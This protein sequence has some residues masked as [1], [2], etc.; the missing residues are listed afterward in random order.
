[1]NARLFLV[2]LYTLLL[3]NTAPANGVAIAD[4]GNLECLH[5]EA[6]RVNALVENQVSQVVARQEFRNLGETPRIVKYGFPL[7][8]DASATRL[9]WRQDGVW[10]EAGIA[11]AP[12]DTTLPGG[13]T[14]HPSLRQHLGNTPLYYDLEEAV[15]PDSQLV[16]ELSYVQLL[17]YDFGRVGFDFPADY[18]LIQ[19]AP[20]DRQEFAFTLESE[21]TILDLDHTGIPVDSLVAGTHFAYLFHDEIEEPADH[22]FHLSYELDPEELGLFGF[23]TLLPDSLLPDAGGNGYFAFV[24]EPDPSQ[25][26]DVIQKVFTLVIDRSGSMSGQ[27]IV[28]ARGAASTIVDNLNPADR[29]NLVSFSSSVHSFRPGHVEATAANRQAAHE[30]IESLYASGSTNVAG[31]FQEAIPQFGAADGTTAN[32]LVFFTDG[33]ANV[34]ES[35]TDGILELVEELDQQNEAQ[36]LIFT[37]GIGAHVNEQLLVRLASE[38]DG[39]CEFLGNDELEERITSFFLRINNPVL[40]DTQINF[41]TEGVSEVYPD[42]LPN[43]YLGS[44]M[45]VSGRYSQ[46]EPLQI[47]LHGTA[48]GQPVSYEY[49]LPVAD[50]LDPERHFLPKIWAKQKIEHLAVAY[51]SLDPESQEADELMEQI[52][53]LSQ[54][55]GVLSPFTSFSGETDIED[56]G[57]TEGEILPV[58]FELPG[59]LP[60]PFN[61]S[62]RIRFRTGVAL[63]RLVEV[64]IYNTLG[65]LVRVLHM[66][67]GGA[68]L[69]EVR[70]DG[71]TEAGRPAA[72]GSY[73][74]VV[75]FGRGLLAD[76]MTLI[77]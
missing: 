8:E 16:V 31:A 56:E 64:R 11:A 37:F 74:Y 61:G 71:L 47:V 54:G 1:M 50:A 10:H 30:Y 35:S 2:P 73:I 76:R 33:L 62:T 14:A 67:V 40:L 12:A 49:T 15:L 7:A 60:N 69:Y 55:Y 17:P 52:I 6:S 34:G 68:G 20:L 77:K 4:A 59:N 13:G 36:T 32:I 9:R 5:L 75:D 24:A 39:L 45:I 27:K 26:T 51:Y 38:H 41:L 18:S 58:L 63:D 57:I 29:F 43:L 44:Q 53:A 19:A 22:D 3:V 65:Q 72:S 21:R 66:E 42:P 28:Q 70:W 23:S 46:P 25:T 48:F